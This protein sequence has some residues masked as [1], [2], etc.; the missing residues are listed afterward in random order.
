MRKIWEVG[1]GEGAVRCCANTGA[2]VWTPSI[3][4]K[5][6]TAAWH[7]TQ[8]HSGKPSLQEARYPGKLLGTSKAHNNGYKVF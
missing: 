3:H 8:M 2:Q 7:N 6:G 4:V 5:L 1:E